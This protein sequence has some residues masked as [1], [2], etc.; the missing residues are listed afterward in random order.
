MKQKVLNDLNGSQA[1]M[2][3]KRSCVYKDPVV[4]PSYN[5]VLT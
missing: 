5:G 1:L 4:M 2:F 3:L